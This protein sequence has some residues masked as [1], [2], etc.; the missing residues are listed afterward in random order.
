M[1]AGVVVNL[2]LEEAREIIDTVGQSEPDVDGFIWDIGG[3][4][5]PLVVDHQGV[6][7]NHR[8]MILKPGNDH[9]LGD[10]AMEQREAGELALPLHDDSIRKWSRP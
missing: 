4:G 1:E 5:A 8:S 9:L 2:S 7:L 3:R 10:R 6:L